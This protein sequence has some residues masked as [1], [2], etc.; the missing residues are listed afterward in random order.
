LFEGSLYIQIF[1]QHPQLTV[2]QILCY[3]FITACKWIRAPDSQV[4]RQL[5]AELMLAEMHEWDMTAF[6]V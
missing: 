1:L 5:E 4:T 3:L 2:T 6:E